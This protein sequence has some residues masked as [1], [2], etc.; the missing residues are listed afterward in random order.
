MK[1]KGI[2]F[3]IFMFLYSSPIGVLAHGT[4]EEHQQEVASNTFATNGLLVSAAILVTGIIS[5]FVMNRRMKT[6]NVKKQ[7]EKGKRD[8]LQKGV[9]IGQ[10]VSIVSLVGVISFGI[11]SFINTKAK[12]I[13]NS[14]ELMHV[15]GLGI[16]N[17]G[18]E[19]YVP[20][21]DGLKVFE[22]GEWRSAKGDKH[23]Y[24]GFSMVDD[25]FYSSGHPEPGSSMKNPFGVVKSNDMGENLEILDLYGEIDFHGMSVG[26]NSHTI[27]VFNPQANSRMDDVGLHYSMDDTKTWVKAELKG[28]SGKLS[29]IAAHPTEEK[30]V[31]LGTTEGVFVS[32]DG[33]QTVNQISNLPVSGLAFSRQGDLFAGFASDKMAIS[34]INLETKEQTAYEIPSLGEGNAINYIAVNPN[35]ENNIVFAT[36]QKDLYLTINNGEEWEKIADKGTGIASHSLTGEG[37]HEDNGE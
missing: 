31:A 17:D 32:H 29:A 24:M 37:E 4:E 22:A 19:I 21:H 28:I 2:L 6:L 8:S 25:G 20:A 10:W 12:D 1:L 26:Y 27:Y 15:H 5:I 16:T 7:K 35:D 13:E 3:S 11:F 33:G 18:E 23:D 36:G 30:T 9:K 34:K 14:V